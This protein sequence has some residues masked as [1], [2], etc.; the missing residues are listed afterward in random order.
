MH[1]SRKTNVLS[2]KTKVEILSWVSGVDT[3][4]LSRKS[5]LL[6]LNVFLNFQTGMITI[7]LIRHQRNSGKES[8]R[9]W[10]N[11]HPNPGRA[12]PFQTL[13]CFSQKRGGV[14]VCVGA[15][16]LTWSGWGPLTITS[17]EER[18]EKPISFTHINLCSITSG[19]EGPDWFRCTVGSGKCR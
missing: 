1:T 13:G 9:P 15:D 4:Y 19:R 10:H 2:T 18:A 6:L 3:D 16:V 11:R 12:N 5:L 17:L 8:H 14:C 7:V